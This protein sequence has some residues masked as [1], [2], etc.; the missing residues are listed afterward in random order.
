MK[1]KESSD[2]FL[3]TKNLKEES[4]SKATLL[5]NS[6]ERFMPLFICLHCRNEIFLYM[7]SELNTINS[8]NSRNQAANAN[9]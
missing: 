6:H 5:L 8:K 2:L 4:K 9:N 7:I 1:M 3:T